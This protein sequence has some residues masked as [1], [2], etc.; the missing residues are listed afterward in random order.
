[1]SDPPQDDS[2]VLVE[3]VIIFLKTLTISPSAEKA[4]YQT[5]EVSYSEYQDNLK[6]LI[7]VE[8]QR[9]RNHRQAVQ[10]VYAY[11]NKKS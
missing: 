10:M 11:Q 8:R 5:H 2:I 1:L 6:F 3:R 7:K 4:F 9:E